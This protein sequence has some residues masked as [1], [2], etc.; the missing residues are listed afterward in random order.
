MEQSFT[1]PN[2]FTLVV[3]WLLCKD[4][5]VFSLY[6]VV[7]FAEHEFLWNWFSECNFSQRTD[8][9]RFLIV[10]LIKPEVFEC[11]CSIFFLLPSLGLMLWGSKS[12]GK[13]FNNQL[14]DSRLSYSNM[15]MHW[16]GINS[17]TMYECICDYRHSKPTQK[18]RTSRKQIQFGW[19]LSVWIG[20]YFKSIGTC[21]LKTSTAS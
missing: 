11:V 20:I 3:A 8:A 15:R 21:K 14:T 9:N 1:T 5:L 10:L 12:S 13:H 19:F 2:D 6:R 4:L 16:N 18:T 17:V 7:C